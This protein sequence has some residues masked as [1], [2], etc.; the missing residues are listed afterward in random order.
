MEIFTPEWEWR[1]RHSSILAM[2]AGYIDATHSEHLRGS[3]A[4]RP[5]D[6]RART[7]IRTQ[8]GCSFEQDLGWAPIATSSGGRA[9]DDDNFWPS[10]WRHVQTY[11][12]VACCSSLTAWLP[13]RPGIF[14]EPSGLQSDFHPE[15]ACSMSRGHCKPCLHEIVECLLPW[16][17]VK[18]PLEFF[19]HGDST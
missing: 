11:C 19:S 3:S 15:L 5:A 7:C 18:T 9:A 17:T 4:Q 14:A 6:L 12:K 8:N 16:A 1:R 2:Q 10:T 13:L